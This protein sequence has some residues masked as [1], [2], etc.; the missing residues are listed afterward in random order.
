V[1]ITDHTRKVLWSL[2]GNASA[3]CD[4]PFVRAPEAAHDSHAIVGRERHV[5]ARSAGGPRGGS[6]PRVALDA[7]ENLILLCANCHAIV[8]AQ[9][10]R[11]T[12]NEARR[13]EAEHESKILAR[14]GRRSTSSCCCS[15][16]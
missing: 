7:Y 16:R 13:I 3:R 14:L 9:P 8:D 10:E 12:P 15:N 5:I 11:F 2:S 1:A 6:G 4:E